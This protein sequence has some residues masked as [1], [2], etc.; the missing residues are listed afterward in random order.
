M[1]EIIHI[2]QQLVFRARENSSD[3]G[4]WLY[5]VLIY[6]IVPDTCGIF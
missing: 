2:P 5:I 1:P 6:G 3:H 4:K